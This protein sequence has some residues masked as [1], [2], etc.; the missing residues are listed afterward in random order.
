VKE[1]KSS[2]ILTYS[3]DAILFQ[4]IKKMIKNYIY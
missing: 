1:S 4:D 3:N 2:V